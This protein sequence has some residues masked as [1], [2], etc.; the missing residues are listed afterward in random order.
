ML[1]YSS[2]S[3]SEVRSCDLPEVAKLSADL[4]GCSELS[5]D[6]Q[7]YVEGKRDPL[8]EGGTPISALVAKCANQVV[9]VAVLRNEKVKNGPYTCKQLSV[10]LKK[11]KSQVY[12]AT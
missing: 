8:V 4:H 12:I 1:L 6:V 11:K 10:Y 9:G 5:E 3:V 7:R 2:F